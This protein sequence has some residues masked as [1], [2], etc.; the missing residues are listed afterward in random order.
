MTLLS[1]ADFALQEQEAEMVHQ[2]GVD[3]AKVQQEQAVAMQWPPR[4][5]RGTRFEVRLDHSCFAFEACF[6]M[7]NAGL[8]R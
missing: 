2:A 5:R 8:I 3:P 1:H 6:G 4:C 7:L